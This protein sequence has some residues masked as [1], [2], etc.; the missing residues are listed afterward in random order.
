MQAAPDDPPER[1]AD[2]RR[3][4]AALLK[5][6]RAVLVADPTASLAQVAQRAE[7]HRATLYRHFPDRET[8][9][10]EIRTQAWDEGLEAMR[11]ARLE[12]GPAEEALARFVR[13]AIAVGDAYRLISITLDGPE[14]DDARRNEVRKPLNALIRRGQGSGAFR[15]DLPATFLYAILRGL[16]GAGI[17]EVEAGD[18]TAEEASERVLASMLDGIRAPA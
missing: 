18:A 12:E 1:R 9:L 5:A 6:A 7:L 3:N 11:E 14:I 13:A 17:R 10:R 15:S 4:R 2:A 8:L 16:L